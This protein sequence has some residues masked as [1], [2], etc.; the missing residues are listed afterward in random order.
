MGLD[1]SFAVVR[2]HVGDPHAVGWGEG[3]CALVIPVKAIR[4]GII[5][6]RLRQG[7]LLKINK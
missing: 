7:A 4:V 3:P 1:T 6:R 2:L 5:I